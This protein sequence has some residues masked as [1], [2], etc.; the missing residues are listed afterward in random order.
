M[1][2]PLILAASLAASLA[3]GAAYACGD[4]GEVI[5]PFYGG[6]GPSAHEQ[7]QALV[8][9]RGFVAELARHPDGESYERNQHELHYLLSIADPAAQHAALRVLAHLIAHP[10]VVIEC[11]APHERFGKEDLAVFLS[12]SYPNREMCRLDAGERKAIV[13]F[14]AEHPSLWRNVDPIWKEGDYCK[15]IKVTP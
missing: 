12:A 11:D 3:P 13:D 9:D 7:G 4:H 14:Y 8:I 2:L 10:A 1:R 15:S 5:G 6:R